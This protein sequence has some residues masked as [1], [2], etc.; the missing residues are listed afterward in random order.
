MI[1][2]LLVAKALGG[3]VSGKNRVS[4]PGPGHSRADR[5]LSIFVDPCLPGGFIVHSFAGDDPLACKDHIRQRLGSGSWR[6]RVQPC[7]L[8]LVSIPNN[9]PDGGSTATTWPRLW[10]NS[11]PV[12]GTPAETYLRSVRGICGAIPVT[13]RFLPTRTNH[14]PAM[15]AAFAMAH[16]PE[17]GV[18]FVPPG[19]LRAVHLTR[20][21]PDG[22]GKADH[23]NPKIILGRG[24]AGVPIVV[25]PPN[26]LLGLAITEGIEDALSVHAATGMGAWAAGGAGRMPALAEAVPDYMDC[27]TIYGDDNKAG[28][29]GATALLRRLSARG[30]FAQIKFFNASMEA[31]N[32]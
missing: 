10:A 21:K 27:V 4:A 23:Q 7:P 31:S 3:T 6:G 32:G 2:L 28:I 19:A 12:L 29:A 5:S 13:L 14:P 25:A 22:M 18:L 9:A 1:D 8:P 11:L 24:A 16:E 20:L 15:V 30:I 17:P 26:D